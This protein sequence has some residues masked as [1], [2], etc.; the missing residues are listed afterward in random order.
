M[1]EYHDDLDY[2]KNL[3]SKRMSAGAIF[4]NENK[5]ILI[6]KPSYKD[7]WDIPGGIVE[8]DESPLQACKREVFEELSLSINIDK[9]LCVDYNSGSSLYTESLSFIFWGGVLRKEDIREIR[10]SESEIDSYLFLSQFSLC[11]YLN[12]RMTKRVKLGL[13]ALELNTSYYL[14]NQEML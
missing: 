10:L 6:V 7:R 4:L 12:E 8:L 5:K 11:D 1:E 14:E 2:Y 9:L 3:P 13:Q